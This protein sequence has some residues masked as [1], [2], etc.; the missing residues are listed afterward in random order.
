MAGDLGELG[1]EGLHALG[2]M[3]KEFGDLIELGRVR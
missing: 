2:G 1:D 3:R